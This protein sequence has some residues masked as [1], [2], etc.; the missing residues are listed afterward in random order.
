MITNSQLEIIDKYVQEEFYYKER[1]IKYLNMHEIVGNEIFDYVDRKNRNLNRKEA[2]SVMLDDEK[3]YEPV[4]V[5]TFVRRIPFYFY[6]WDGDIY[7]DSGSENIGHI[8]LSL[9]EEI[10]TGK[11]SV[12]LIYQY[13]EY[14]FYEK[15]IEPYYIFNYMA[16]QTGLTTQAYFLEWIEYLHLCDDLG[17]TNTIPKNFITA[18]N[19]AREASGLEPRI[20]DP[21]WD[22][23][24]DKPYC[25]SGNVLEFEGV[26]P[27]DENRQP[28]MKWIGL[29]IKNG[30][31]VVEC[32]CIKAKSGFLR[33][34]IQPNT[35]VYIR[36][37]YKGEVFWNQVYAGPLTMEFDHS[38]LKEYRKRLNYTQQEVADAVGAN[39]RT[40]QKWEYGSTQPDGYYLLRLMN[41]LDI[42]SAQEAVKFDIP[43]EK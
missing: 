22:M 7:S 32:T 36:D 5:D 19:T 8:F 13:F 17:W 25:K 3:G 35:V 4:N 30:Y 15:G 21:I 33:I 16:E 20:Y 27:C 10:E 43:E 11:I 12:E 39:L 41:W 26:F 6:T 18:Y 40:Y 38:I 23:H 42:S 24:Q 1:L 9:W 28:I 14:M 37:Y 31:K 34:E 29:K 2:H